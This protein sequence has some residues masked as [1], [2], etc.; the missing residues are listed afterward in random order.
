MI[1]LFLLQMVPDIDDFIEPFAP[2]K[3][4]YLTTT[5][6]RFS[7]YNS[8]LWYYYFGPPSVTT[9]MTNYRIS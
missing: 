6:S 3:L 4:I 8:P 2:E 1:L 9:P 5:V 7:I